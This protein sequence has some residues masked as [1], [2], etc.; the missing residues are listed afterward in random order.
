MNID[1]AHNLS[2][3]L[4]EE[5]VNHTIQVGV[6]PNMLP[7]VQCRVD[8]P[9]SRRYSGGL[10]EWITRLEGIAGEHDLVLGTAF[11]GEGLT[12]STKTETDALLEKLR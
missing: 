2:R 1:R 3:R 9:L 12:F 8:V 10:G 6:Y 7:E 11:M 4:A 5:G